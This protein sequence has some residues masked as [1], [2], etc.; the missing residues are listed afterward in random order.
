MIESSDSF[1]VARL[2]VIA[3]SVSACAGKSAPEMRELGGFC[4][5]IRREIDSLGSYA[6]IPAGSKMLPYTLREVLRHHVP[7]LREEV[8]TMLSQMFPPQVTVL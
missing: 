4:Q 1:R 7:E 3:N 2:T 6:D 5:V 8:Q